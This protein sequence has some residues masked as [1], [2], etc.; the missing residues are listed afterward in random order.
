MTHNQINLATHNENVRHNKEMERQGWY[1]AQSNALYQDRQGRA[2]LESARAATSQAGSAW[3]NAYA[4]MSNAE[5]NSRN[6][7]TNWF[8][9]TET[10]QRRLE[11]LQQKREEL[12][13]TKRQNIRTYFNNLGQ[14]Q[15]LNMQNEI[16]KTNAKT[17]QLG[18]WTNALNGAMSNA[19]NATRGISSVIIG[20]L[21]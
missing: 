2:S 11:E 1:G 9:A 17:A 8:T 20:G 10:N 15:A 19:I 3:T 14:L 21:K 18:M 7:N 5:T 13:E 4:N 6:A 16:A 12:L